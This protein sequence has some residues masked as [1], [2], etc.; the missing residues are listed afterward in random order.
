MINIP[1]SQKTDTGY[2]SQW[3]AVL[4]STLHQGTN[5]DA[6]LPD[7]QLQDEEEQVPV[8]QDTPVRNTDVLQDDYYSTAIDVIADSMTIQWEKPVTELFTTD[9]VTVSNKKVGCIFITICLQQ[10]LEEYSP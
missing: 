7:D 2:S 8:E 6:N 9:E 4:N 5:L 3:Q 1:E 10:Y